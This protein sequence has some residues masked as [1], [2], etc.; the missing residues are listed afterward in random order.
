MTDSDEHPAATNRRTEDE[1][2]PSRVLAHRY[3][4]PRVR[5]IHPVR[6]RRAN[7]GVRP[8]PSAPTPGRAGGD[9]PSRPVRVRQARSA[10]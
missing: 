7:V 5:E 1:E 4:R 10:A 2:N 3:V 9:G 6:T 8:S